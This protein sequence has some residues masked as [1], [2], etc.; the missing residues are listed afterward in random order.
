MPDLLTFLALAAFVLVLAGL[1]EGFVSRAPL[2]FPIIFL[3]L[4]VVLGYRGVISLSPHS[5]MLEAV[6]VVTLSL[7][8]FL[9]A[10]RMKFDRSASEWLVPSLVLGPGTILCLLLVAIAAHFLFGTGIA[11][12]I[13]IGAILSSTDPVVVRDIVRDQR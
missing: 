7:V 12:S 13:L 3:G 6:A 11:A 2:S 1:T 4:G 8:L 9:D 10:V 5:P